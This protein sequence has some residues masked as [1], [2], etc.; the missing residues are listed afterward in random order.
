M[1]RSDLLYATYGNTPKRPTLNAQRLTPNAERLMHHASRFAPH[2]SRFTLSSQFISFHL[3][4]CLITGTGSKGH[5]GKGRIFGGSG[6]H[7]GV[8]CELRF[9]FN[10]QTRPDIGYKFQTVQ[11]SA[12]VIYF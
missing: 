10:I 5:I 4:N 1:R 11:Q 2:A 7:T 6:G 9:I 8:N 3:I 12:V